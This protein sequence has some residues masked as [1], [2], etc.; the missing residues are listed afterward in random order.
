MPIFREE[1]RLFFS[2]MTLPSTTKSNDKRNWEEALQNVYAFSLW[3]GRHPFV[4]QAT[5]A[6]A[7]QY[8]RVILRT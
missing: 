7:I 5:N 3:G 1:Q 6:L 4:L 8:T 2:A